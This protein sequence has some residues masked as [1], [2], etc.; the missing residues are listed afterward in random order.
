MEF[1]NISLSAE[2]EI[3]ILTINR[4]K[5]LNALNIETLKDI[6]A[7]IQEVRNHPECKVLIITGAGEKAFVAGADIAEMRG[8]NS[9]EALDF[10]KLGHLTLKMVQ[11]LDRPVIAAV[12]GYALGGGT[13]IALACDLIYA[14]ENAKFGL[15]EVTLGVFPGFG[16]TQR[17]SRLIG[18][19]KAKELIFT[20]KIISA[21]EAF[22]MGI[23]NRVFPQASLMEET[24][25]LAAPIAGNGP[26]GVRLAKMVVD[27]GFNMDLTEAC[28][29]ES[30]AFSIAFATEDQKEGMT[31][32]L[33]KRKPG[34]KGR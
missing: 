33:E 2:N 3:G 20:G 31:A 34:F 1:K 18:K 6:Q 7:G 17:L 10:S 30:Y 26:V 16:G 11:D 12:N 24:K 23:V 22:D 21:S 19:G 5:A 9:I 8:M 28:S 15:P 4:P 32:F 14:S 25:K 27:A 29:L 13:E